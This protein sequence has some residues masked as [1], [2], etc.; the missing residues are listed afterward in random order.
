VIDRTIRVTMGL[1]GDQAVGIE[2]DPLAVA[3]LSSVV[4]E[5][6]IEGGTITLVKQGAE[7]SAN[8]G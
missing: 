4:D 5:Y 1:S 2:L 6:V 8:A 3:V 7:S